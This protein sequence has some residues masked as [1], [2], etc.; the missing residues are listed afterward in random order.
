MINEEDK[1]QQVQ[2][3]DSYVHQHINEAY[4]LIRDDKANPPIQ[5]EIRLKEGWLNGNIHI[6]E[7]A[8]TLTDEAHTWDVWLQIETG[9]VD[10]WATVI[11]TFVRVP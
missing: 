6:S 4:E 9:I 5:P 8:P 2:A 10:N 1:I 7:L 3:R 11:N